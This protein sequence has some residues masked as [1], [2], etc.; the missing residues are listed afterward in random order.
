VSTFDWYQALEKPSWAPA[1]PVF[2]IAWSII[3]P[4]IIVTFGWVFF[5]TA[6]GRL[7]WI[8]ALPFALNLVCNLAFTPIQFGLRS[9]VLAMVDILAVIATLAWAVVAIWPYAPWVGLAQIPYLA[10]GSFATCLQI[11]ITILNRNG[12]A[13]TG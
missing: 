12:G 9:N 5:R 4:I 6:T 2:G 11:A 1:P 3:Y 7:P 13:G 8:V 10:W